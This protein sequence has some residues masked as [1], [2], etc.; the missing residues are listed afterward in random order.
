MNRQRVE[1][2][3]DFKA[4]IAAMIGDTTEHSAR[5]P[6]PLLVR[7]KRAIR[8]PKTAAAMNRLATLESGGSACHLAAYLSGV[9]SRGL[10]IDCKLQSNSR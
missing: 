2:T 5:R 6:N 3:E 7:K 1:T 10:E 9:P 4:R 8:T